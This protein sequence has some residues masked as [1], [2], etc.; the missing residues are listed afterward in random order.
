M[1]GRAALLGFGRFGGALGSLLE[2]AGVSYRALDPAVEVPPAHRAASIAEL[3]DAAEVIFLAVPIPELQ[4]ALRQL[5]PH[6]RADHL[7]LDVASVKLLPQRLMAEQLGGQVPWVGT[8]PLFGPT[9]LGLGERPLHVIVCPSPQHP[10]ASRRARELYEALGCEVVEQEAEAHDRGMARTHALAF[11]L[12]KGLLDIGVEPH[13]H[14]APPSSRALARTIEAVRSDAG[15]L[16]ATIHSA[17]PFA[18]EARRALLESLTRV[19]A[20]LRL[21]EQPDIPQPAQDEASAT[22]ASLDELSQI[23]QQLDELDGELVALLCR[24]AAL[25]RAAGRAKATAGRPVQDRKR[26]REL[27]ESRRRSAARAGLDPAAIADIFEAVLRFSRQV[28]QKEETGE[29]C[30]P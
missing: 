26:E 17:N 20:Q 2:S 10:T 14:A 27:L 4:R 23:R 28:Q 12:A 29:S 30:P 21:G 24:R 13:L 19:D 6:L 22:R 1:I 7:V 9:S 18:E 25:A 15:H 11:F 3:V 5:Q 8:H 16:F